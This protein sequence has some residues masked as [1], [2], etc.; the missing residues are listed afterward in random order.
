MLLSVSDLRNS[1]Y[2][3]GVFKLLMTCDSDFSPAL[4]ASRLLAK[5]DATLDEKIHAYLQEKDVFHQYLLWIEDGKVVGLVNFIVTI[6]AIEIDT[7]C[8]HP[9]YRKKGIAK[10]FYDHLVR[11]CP[12]FELTSISV[13]CNK[14]AVAHMQLLESLG[15]VQT[16]S[17]EKHIIYIK[18]SA[19]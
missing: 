6:D 1:S 2:R 11:L 19:I 4:S 8:V 12:L 3:D 10:H 13:V 5:Q 18:K 14:T 16:N 15:F 9:S 17:S 7:I